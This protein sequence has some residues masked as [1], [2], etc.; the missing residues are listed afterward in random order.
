[1]QA[2]SASSGASP[3]CVAASEHT[4]GRLSQNA[5]P[6]LKS[7]ASAT[8]APRRRARA[9]AASA[10][11]ERARSR[12]TARRRRR[13]PRARRPRRARRLQVVDGA[14][15]ELDRER[16]RARLRELV[17][18]EPQRQTRARGSRQVAPGLVGVERSAFEEH[19]RR[20]REPCRLRQ[21]LREQEVD[22]GVAPRRTRA[23]R[24]GRRATSRPRPRRGPRASWASSVSRSSPYPGLRLERRRPRPEHPADMT[25]ER[26]RELVPGRRASRTNRR[27]DPA[28]ARVEL[29]VRR[30]RAPER[31]LLDA[32]AG[33]ARVRV[34][35][36]EP[37]DRRQSAPVDLLDVAGERSAAR[38]MRPTAAILPPR[39]GRTRRRSRRAR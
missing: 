14:R 2:A 13:S 3:S 26:G 24:R 22:V 34:A 39:R 38:V 28:A 11:R 18:V 16:D 6:G 21:H 23:A 36:D 9:P 15:A 32:V 29:L 17:A 19:V 10:D 37:G 5:L 7:V 27:E 25:L 33:E 31:E 35:V 1:M 8:A 30:S 4:S 20:I 12:A